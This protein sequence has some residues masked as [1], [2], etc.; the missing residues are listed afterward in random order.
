[1]KYIQ[2]FEAGVLSEIKRLPTEVLFSFKKSM[3]SAKN[4]I[5]R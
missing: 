2:L 1:M 5:I 3:K 4:D